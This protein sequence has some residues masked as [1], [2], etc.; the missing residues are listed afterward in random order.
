MWADRH[1][2]FHQL[3][4]YRSGDGERYQIYRQ[5]TSP[6]PQILRGTSRR[7]HQARDI[8]PEIVSRHD[9]LK[10]NLTRQSSMIT[11]R[12]PLDDTGKL[13]AAFNKRGACRDQILVTTIR[14]LSYDNKSR[15][16]GKINVSQSARREMCISWMMYII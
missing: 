2:W 4:Q 11:H 9:I 12:V 16:S 10:Q 13:Y 7:V 5:W 3:L 1:T 14:G 8:R 6:G 15:R